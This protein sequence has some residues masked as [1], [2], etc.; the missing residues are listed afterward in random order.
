M[1]CVLSPTQDLSSPRTA[2][3]SKAA[4]AIKLF[5]DSYNIAD[6]WRFRNPTRRSYSFYSPVQKSYSHI[7]Y[8][9]LDSGLLP[10]VK[11]CE[12]QAIVISDHAPLL[13][14]LCIPASHDTYRPWRFNTLLLSDADFVKFVSKEITEYL[15]CDQT[16]GMSSSVIW[17]SMKAYLRGQIISYSAHVK[18]TLSKG[19]EQLTKSILE[20]DTKIANTT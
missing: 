13:L 6:T 16:P 4:Q 20:L 3:L 5:L 2:T 9:F 14:T 10:M 11:E 1:N 7:D 17:E 12:Y 18:K 15:A 19:H 8:F